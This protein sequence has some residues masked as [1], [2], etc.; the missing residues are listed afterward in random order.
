M[1]RE[2]VVI[3]PI[4][5]DAKWFRSLAHEY[6]RIAQVS[7]LPASARCVYVDVV[8]STTKQLMSRI[9]HPRASASGPSV[10]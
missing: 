8:E 10:G 5:S 1:F 3:L 6:R 9:R 2:G 7:Q 4:L